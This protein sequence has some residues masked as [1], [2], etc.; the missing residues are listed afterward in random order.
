MMRKRASFGLP[1]LGTKSQDKHR[2]KSRRSTYNLAETGFEKVYRKAYLELPLNPKQVDRHIIRWEVVKLCSSKQ[3][4][5]LESSRC[6][7]KW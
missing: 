2:T 1:K 4:K 6:N 5:D 7:R 3:S